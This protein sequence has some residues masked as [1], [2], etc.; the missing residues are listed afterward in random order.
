MSGDRVVTAVTLANGPEIAYHRGK[1]FKRFFFGV[2]KIKR[3]EIWYCSLEV[4]GKFGMRPLAAASSWMFMVDSRWLV[5][6]S[7]VSWMVAVISWRALDGCSYFLEGSGWLLLI[8]DGLPIAQAAGYT[9]LS[10]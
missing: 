4:R 7:D 8:P 6:F 3:G 5:L 9:P 1:K 2:A 10:M